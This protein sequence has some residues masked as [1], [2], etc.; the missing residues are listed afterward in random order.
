[1]SAL[2]NLLHLSPSPILHVHL[3]IDSEMELLREQLKKGNTY[4]SKELTR[5]YLSMY[6]EESMKYKN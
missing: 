5:I 2:V 1:M 3:V 4:I 6:A